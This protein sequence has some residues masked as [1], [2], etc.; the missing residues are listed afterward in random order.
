MKRMLALALACLLLSGCALIPG[1]THSLEKQ[2]QTDETIALPSTEPAE[3]LPTEPPTEP[4]TEPPPVY[5]NPLTGVILDAPIT[6]RPVCVSINNLQPSLPHSGVLQSDLYFETF[7][8]GSIIRGLAMFADPAAAAKIGSV[9]ST[10]FMFTDICLRYD[11]IMAHAGGSG[12]VLSDAEAR[13]NSNFN[14][15]TPNETS[16]SFR[17]PERKGKYSL[18]HTLFAKG[19]G[20]LNRA[21]ELGIDVSLNPDKDFCLRFS[22]DPVPAEGEEANEIT[23][24]I[25]Y[26]GTIKKDTTLIYQPESG[27]YLYHQYA[28]DMTDEL[29]GEPETFKNVIIM[30]GSISTN[31]WNYQ[32]LDFASGGTGY[33]AAN[34]RIV[35]ITWSAAGESDAV[36]FFTADGAP[37]ALNVGN[38]YV[39]ITQNES[40]IVW[41]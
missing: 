17:D 36:S 10:R 26:K 24:T 33:Y 21:A 14:I 41:Q 25:L 30:E 19:E 23:V 12:M 7:V 22:D 37:L 5:R 38:S 8:N 34:G 40:K 29:T 31:Q 18:E 27:R 16:W 4:T 35:P 1:R 20:L 15:D 39:A 2:M 13:Q 32:R 9:R 6:T 11:A 28:K 3:E